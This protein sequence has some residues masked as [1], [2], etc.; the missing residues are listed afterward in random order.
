MTDDPSKGLF[1]YLVGPQASAINAFRCI[2][3]FVTMFA[4]LFLKTLLTLGMHT[5]MQK[6]MAKKPS[7]VMKFLTGDDFLREIIGRGILTAVF[8]LLG[9]IIIGKFA[10]SK[11]LVGPDMGKKRK[12]RQTQSR[13]KAKSPLLDPLWAKEQ[14]FQ[15][16]PKD[17]IHS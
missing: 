12:K 10:G 13:I 9:W 3:I 15:L 4:G 5:T 2:V 7:D 14:Y 6:Y 8:Q 17:L 1:S 16:V 11:I